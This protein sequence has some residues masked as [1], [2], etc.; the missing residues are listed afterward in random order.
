MSSSNHDKAQPTQVD[1]LAPLAVGESALDQKL[2]RHLGYFSGTMMNVGQI[3][4][5]GIFSNPALILQNCGSGGMMLI[6]WIIGAI[7]AACGVWSY[8]E[9]GTM[10]PRS[11]GEKEYL[12][13]QFP[14][15]KHLVSFVFLITIG[16]FG[17]GSGIAQG[18]TVFGNNIIYAIG[19]PTYTSPWGA[20]GFAVFCVTFWIILNIIS[21]KWAIKFNNFFTVLKIA[22]LILLIGVGFAGLAG[23]LPDQPNLREN[24]SFNNTN[25]NAGSYANAIYYVIFA[26][27]G[28]YNL[29]YVLDELKDPIKNLPRC[30][31]SALSLTTL[32]YLLANIAYLAVLPISVIESSNL[33][34]A[35]NLFNKPSGASSAR[36]FYQCSS[37]CRHSGYLP[38]DRFFAATH[39]KLHTPINSLALLYVISL[40]FM[41][42]PPPGSVFQFII[43]FAG[44][45]SYFFAAL[46]VIGLLLLRR[47]EPHNNRPIR[48]PIA[49]FYTMVFVFIPPTKKPAD[50]PYYLPYLLSIVLGILS[51]GLWYIKMIKNDGLGNSYNTEIRDAGRQE[52]YQ[53]VFDGQHDNIK[54][55]E[56]GTHVVFEHTNK[57]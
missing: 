56:N 39:S 28:W 13:Y 38:Y 41:L 24:F 12:A 11:G 32:L 55:A 33:T 30:A 4:G 47:W 21:A 40:I 53:D 17:R 5:T 6:L 29:N 31:V 16:V 14:N 22:L 23:S 48:V 34:V 51:I 2:N 57:S 27:G 26:Y 52:L 3:I 9:L 43:A 18:A 37:G 19:G 25:T 35:A 42:A 7:F 10:L 15:P 49:C 8:L 20:R 36:R 45:G 44:Y 50:Y 46:S 54:R 1:R